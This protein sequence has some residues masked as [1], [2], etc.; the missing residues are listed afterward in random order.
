[1]LSDEVYRVFQLVS[2]VPVNDVYVDI[3]HDAR[4]SLQQIHMALKE[5]EANGN[6]SSRQADI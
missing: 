1:M 2:K 6:S 3:M 5:M 4:V